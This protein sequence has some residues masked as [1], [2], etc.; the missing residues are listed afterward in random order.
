MNHSLSHKHESEQSE[1]ASRAEQATERGGASERANGRASG[2]VL[3]SVFLVI[4]AHSAKE[5]ERRI[6]RGEKEDKTE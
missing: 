2:Q 3:Q 4:L 5:K 1:Q 6:R